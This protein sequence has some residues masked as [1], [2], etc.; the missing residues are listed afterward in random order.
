MTLLAG[1]DGVHQW[2]YD[3]HMQKLR[4]DLKKKDPNTLRAI[5]ALQSY[6][7]HG[8]NFD[9][10]LMLLISKADS[11]NKRSLCIAFPYHVRVFDLWYG[12]AN[13]QEFFNYLGLKFK[14]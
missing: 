14:I 4:E 10:L 9:G 12:A 11:G 13:E 8:D 7:G 5:N 6:K 1:P 3:E 2:L